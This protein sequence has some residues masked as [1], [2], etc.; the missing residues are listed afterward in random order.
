MIRRAPE[1]TSACDPDYRE[2]GLV[3]P[4]CHLEC[5]NRWMWPDRPADVPAAPVS[6][7]RPRRKA[8]RCSGCGEVGHKRPTCRRV[9]A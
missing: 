8:A 1:D 6:Q 5:F 7:V 9:A 2:P 3:G 4:A